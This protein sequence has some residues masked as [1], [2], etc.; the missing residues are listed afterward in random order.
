MPPFKLAGLLAEGSLHPKITPALRSPLREIRAATL[1]ALAGI[2]S[3]PGALSAF[4]SSPA[5][6]DSIYEWIGGVGDAL[7]D[8]SHAVAAGAHA[9]AR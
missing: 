1:N 7:L 5:T 6:A 9:C 2:P 3:R 4:G 8:A